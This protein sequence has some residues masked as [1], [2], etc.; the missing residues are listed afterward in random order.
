MA[1]IAIKTSTTIRSRCWGIFWHLVCFAFRIRASVCGSRN[2]CRAL[3]AQENYPHLRLPCGFDG[4]CCFVRAARHYDCAAVLAIVTNLYLGILSALSALVYA[5]YSGVPADRSDGH[6]EGLVPG[7]GYRFRSVGKSGG[8]CLVASLPWH[9]QSPSCGGRGGGWKRRISTRPP[10]FG[11]G[12]CIGNAAGLAAGLLSI[13]L[14]SV[15][16]ASPSA[17]RSYDERHLASG[18]TAVG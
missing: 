8:E 1:N 16:G 14:C 3:A 15:L 18:S 10:L 13:A 17:A 9:W 7:H 6:W 5:T 2:C 12:R 4:V 11:K